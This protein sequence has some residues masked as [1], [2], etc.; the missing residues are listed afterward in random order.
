MLQTVQKAVE[1]LRL[2]TPEHPEWGV[3]EVALKLELPKSGA[4]ALLCTLAGQGLLERTAN[5]RYRLGW[6]L[7][8]LSQTLLENS[9]LLRVARPIMERLA[10]GWGAT[11]HLAVL[12]DG[13][14]LYVEKIQGD[15]SF[16]ILLSGVGKRLP[17]HCS[18]VGK[19]LLA[20]RPWDEMA[21]IVRENGLRRFT[22]NTITDVEQLRAELELIR[23][24][25]YAYDLEEVM[26]GL[27]CV[28][29]PIHDESEQVIAAM[30]LSVPAHRFYPDQ[31]RLTTAIVDTARR[32]SEELGYPCDQEESSWWTDAP[33]R[34]LSSAP[35]TSART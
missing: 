19:V 3:T 20:Y 2:F 1:V 10:T 32:V 25:G 5:R 11:T 34:S 33:S 21:R 26:V 6:R 8:E 29:V 18:G 16:E 23:Q 24:R 22:P 4:H 28:A 7:F 14:V 31:H 9:R 15:P 17:A 35:G 27:C 12:I 30:S 13:R